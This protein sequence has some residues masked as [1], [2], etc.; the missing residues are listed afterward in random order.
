MAEFASNAH[1]WVTFAVIVIALGFYAS[2]VA[3]M[4]LTSLGVI[5]VLLVLFHVLPIVDADGINRLGPA[6]ILAGF[7]SP[8]LLTVL[9]LLVIGEGLVRTGALDRVAGDVLRLSGGGTWQPFALVLV[10]VVAVSG[11]LLGD[12]V[13]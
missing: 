12:V 3:P 7:A 11:F 13:E 6:R 9:A 4:E 2:E 10:V 5:C 1:M 8:A